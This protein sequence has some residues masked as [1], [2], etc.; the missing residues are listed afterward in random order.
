MRTK[1]L[2]KPL[3]LALSLAA[4]A[5]H[6]SSAPGVE[7]AQADAIANRDACERAG[8]RFEEGPG[9]FACFNQRSAPQGPCGD[10]GRSI[11]PCAPRA[12]NFLDWFR[13][14]A[15]RL[16]SPRSGR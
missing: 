15:G 7:L 4:M 2:I 9:Y 14:D 6:A 16:N 3:L 13:R 12:R 5:A 10:K 8:G 11:D 1:S